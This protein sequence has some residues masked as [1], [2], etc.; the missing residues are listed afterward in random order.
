MTP[1]QII[2]G[3][4][5]TEVRNSMTK[6]TQTIKEELIRIGLDTGQHQ[7]AD[8]LSAIKTGQ[9][10]EHFEQAAVNSIVIPKV[11]KMSAEPAERVAK[12]KKVKE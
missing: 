12:T 9:I 10:P 6:I 3:I 5:R 7:I 2:I 8:I 11:M 4:A 1:D